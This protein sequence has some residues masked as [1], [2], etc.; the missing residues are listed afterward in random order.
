MTGVILGAFGA[1]ALETLLEET[2]RTDVFHTGTRYQM[3][4]ALLL[5]IL[6]IISQKQTSKWLSGSSILIFAGTLVF[7]G[8]LY[9]LCIFDLPIMGAVTP[10]GGAML[11]LGWGAMFI[12]FLKSKS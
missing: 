6:A 10:F 2:G 9:I 1:H 3:Y 7:S 5:L 8:S 12:H 4:H 11:I